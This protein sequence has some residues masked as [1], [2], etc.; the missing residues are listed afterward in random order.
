MPSAAAAAVALS[1]RRPP[2][3]FPR[4]Q[5]SRLRQLLSAI[6][7]TRRCPSKF[8]VEI[9]TF[10]DT[11]RNDRLT[12]VITTRNCSRYVLIRQR[13]NPQRRRQLLPNP[14]RVDART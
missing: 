10:H 12:V 6:V 3:H 2:P 1:K 5:S 13:Q 9:T 11:V 4:S 14:I 7:P 8:A